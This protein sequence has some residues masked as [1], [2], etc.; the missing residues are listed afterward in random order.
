MK[1][2][3]LRLILE[4][5]TSASCPSAMMLLTLRFRGHCC[6]QGAPPLFLA[7]VRRHLR[8]S[9]DLF[10]EETRLILTPCL[11]AFITSQQQQLSQQLRNAATCQ[12]HFVNKPKKRISD[13]APHLAT[14]EFPC[15][16]SHR[17]SQG[18]VKIKKGEEEKKRKENS[19]TSATIRMVNL[20]CHIC[21]LGS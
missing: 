13:K 3:L 15:C 6:T 10:L 9:I 21:K 1:G 20:A 18:L 5:H 11:S 17:Q 14:R 19:K 4:Q 12:T 8:L 16:Q 7:G 2:L